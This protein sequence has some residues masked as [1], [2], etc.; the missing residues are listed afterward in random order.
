[1]S[2]IRVEFNGITDD[3]RLFLD[4]SNKVKIKPAYRITERVCECGST[5][6]YVRLR[7][8]KK[9]YVS[10]Y[11]KKCTIQMNKKY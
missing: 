11:C 10:K 1:M 8:G 5:D 7:N 6:F 9:Q 4:N 3:I 2:K